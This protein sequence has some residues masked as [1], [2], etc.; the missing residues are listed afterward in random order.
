[1]ESRSSW[2]TDRGDTLMSMATQTKTKAKRPPTKAK[3]RRRKIKVGD[4]VI[5]HFGGSQ[6]PGKVTED[7]GPLADGGKRLLRIASWPEPGEEPIM[8]EIPE[9]ELELAK[10]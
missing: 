9:E 1:M 5:M 2:G 7:R 3:P 4:E 6:L 8:W 10:P